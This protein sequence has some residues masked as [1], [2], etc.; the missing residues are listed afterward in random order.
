[1]RPD[2]S[3][4][5]MSPRRIVRELNRFVIGQDEAKRAVAIALRNRWRRRQVPE[6]MRDEI[7]PF[8]I[9]LIG[10]TGVGKTEIARRLAALAQAPFIKVEA[11]RFTEVGYVGRD[12]DSMIRDLVDLAVQ[13]EREQ[14]MS[15][16][17]QDVQSLVRQRLLDLLLEAR[18]GIS[19]AGLAE[20]LDGGELEEFELRLNVEESPGGSASLQVFGAG[21]F[22]E[23]TANLQEMMGEMMQPQSRP[24][25]MALHQARQHL[26]EEE[27][28]RRL[29]HEQVARRA[30]QRCEE[31]GI[32]FVDEIDKI[33]A[34]PEGAGPDV[35]RQ[36]VQKDILPVIEGTVVQTK[37]GPVRT[38]HMLFLASGAFHLSRPSDLIP[39]LQG[40][41]PVR[42]ELDSLDRRALHSILT[43]PENALVKQYEALFAAEGVELVMEPEACRELARFAQEANRR[44]E[45]IG[46]RRL[47]GLMHLLL[48][49]ELFRLPDGR[50]K[51]LRVDANMVRKRL[52]DAI[53]DVD[54][55]RYIL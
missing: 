23:I 8:N 43:K 17:R 33:C 19:E 22:E 35:S 2:R 5:S 38:H 4:E 9:I 14:A 1:M 41:F 3:T 49:E 15:A 7:T 44:A 12:V 40:R 30:V 29:D 36:G 46:A 18:P 42:V 20:A 24:R 47:H 55:S 28:G 52:A 6:P 13:S 25:D 32:V 16:Q 11:S 48:E 45:N 39:E 21:G 34:P 37:Y 26:I 31:D 27:A 10:S 50:L 54:L 51:Q 53:E